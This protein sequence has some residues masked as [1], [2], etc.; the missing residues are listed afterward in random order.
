M[1]RVAKVVA[2]NMLFIALVSFNSCKKDIK[3]KSKLIE[4]VNEP[5]NG[6]Q[7]SQ[8]V[9]KVETSLTYK[10]WQL[11]AINQ[12][13]VKSVTGTPVLNNLKN[14]YFFVLSLSAN[15]KELLKQLKF[16]DYSEMVQV[17]AFR[18]MAY[19]SAVPDNGKPVAP[20]DCLFQQTYGMGTANQILI[21]F[22]KLKFD[23]A[24]EIDIRIKEF[25]LNIGNLNYRFNI[26]DIDDLQNIV[27]NN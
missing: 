8:Q 14:K 12:Q 6:L 3:S 1:W 23:K 25:G 15:H 27:F 17:M 26:K 11:M 13:K 4:Y 22:D 18:M 16:S 9:G 20:E 24:K 5:K 7:M 21:V 2:I 19:V 10:P